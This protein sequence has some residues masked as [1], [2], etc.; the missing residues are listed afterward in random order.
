MG[1]MLEEDVGRD[2]RLHKSARAT[3]LLFTIPT[4]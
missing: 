2:M 1:T 3:F 4:N